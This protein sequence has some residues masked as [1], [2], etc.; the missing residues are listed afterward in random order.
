[1][2]ARPKDRPNITLYR[3]ELRGADAPQLVTL[4]VW[5][6]AQQYR[7]LTPGGTKIAINKATLYGDWLQWYLDPVAARDAAADK[8]MKTIAEGERADGVMDRL[9]KY[10]IEQPVGTPA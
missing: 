6:T 9:S 10:V 1:M 2:T 7:A 4:D 3:F 5:E 8:L